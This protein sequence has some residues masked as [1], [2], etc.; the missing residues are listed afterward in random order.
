MTEVTKK[1][2]GRAKLEIVTFDAKQS[3][4]LRKMA[5]AAKMTPPEYAAM[6]LDAEM[7]LGSMVIDA[8]EAQR[9]SCAVTLWRRFVGWMKGF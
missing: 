8:S 1:Q 4:Y 7:E 3:R 9:C 5:K 6:V 2:P